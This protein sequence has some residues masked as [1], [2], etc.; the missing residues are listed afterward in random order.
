MAVACSPSWGSPVV[1]ACSSE[2]VGGVFCISG[3][4]CWSPADSD[5]D[6]TQ[7]TCGRGMYTYEKGGGAGIAL[8][9]PY[10]ASPTDENP[11][12]CLLLVA[13]LGLSYTSFSF[14]NLSLC[15]HTVCG[16]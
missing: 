9:I 5:P 15:V 11:C 4:C 8:F 12:R 1:F 7:L 6:R 13:G 10:V 3:E 2:L 16:T 14:H